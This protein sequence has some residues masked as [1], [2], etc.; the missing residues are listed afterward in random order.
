M[1][2][3]EPGDEVTGVLEVLFVKA[4]EVQV[5][6][7]DCLLLLGCLALCGDLLHC[8]LSRGTDVHALE[9][10]REDVVDATQLA[11]DL[12]LQILLLLE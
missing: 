10:F 1:K 8:S 4:V 6:V 2:V 12:C 11:C 3:F 5:F 9:G 7:G